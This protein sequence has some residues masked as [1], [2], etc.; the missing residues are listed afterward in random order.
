MALIA[1]QAATVSGLSPTMTQPTASDTIRPTERSALI[2]RTTGTAT[3]VTF[4]IPG[5]DAFETAKPDKAITLAATDLKVIPLVAYM[6]AA[7]SSGIVPVA[8][9]GALTGVT[10]AQVEI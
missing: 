3:T 4:T 7:D 8:F 2:V 5:N 1:R 9:S 6:A 10:A